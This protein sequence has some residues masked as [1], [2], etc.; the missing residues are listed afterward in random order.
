M[1]NHYPTFIF[2]KHTHPLLVWSEEDV[3]AN[4]AF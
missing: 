2:L 3:L 4:Y 1:V